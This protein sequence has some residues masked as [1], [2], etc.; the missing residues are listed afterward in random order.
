VGGR[1]GGGGRYWSTDKYGYNSG[2]EKSVSFCLLVTTT[3]NLKIM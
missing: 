3:T 2:K 1:G